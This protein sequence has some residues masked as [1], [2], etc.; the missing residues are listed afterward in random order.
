MRLDYSPEIERCIMN[1]IRRVQL[2]EKLGLSLTTIWRL[3]KRGDFPSRIRLSINAVGYDLAEI[4]R[5]LA[6]REKA[7]K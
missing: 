1:I 6:T 5:W 4:D 2:V 7:A 3:E